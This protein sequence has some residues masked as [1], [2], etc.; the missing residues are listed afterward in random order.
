MEPTFVT[1]QRASPRT[2]GHDA[3]YSAFAPR[4]HKEV[5]RAS[6]LVDRLHH[7]SRGT[8]NRSHNITLSSR[9][10][11]SSINTILGSRNNRVRLV[12]PATQTRA[13][14]R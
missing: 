14:A 13:G 1:F 3:I 6:I 5:M 2:K 11:S 8:V 9:M 10:Y 7:N 4:K 12:R